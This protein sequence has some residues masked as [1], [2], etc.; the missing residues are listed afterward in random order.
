M[1]LPDEFHLTFFF[2]FFG[3][4]RKWSEHS[5]TVTYNSQNA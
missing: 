3:R 5:Q 1:I 2:F 4:E